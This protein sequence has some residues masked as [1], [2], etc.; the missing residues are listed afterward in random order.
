MRCRDLHIGKDAAINRRDYD[1]QRRLTAPDFVQDDR[2]PLVG[3]DDM[4]RARVAAVA[5]RYGGNPNP[6]LKCGRL[7]IDLARRF[8]GGYGIVGGNLPIAAGFGLA[9]D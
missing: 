4:R 7:E 3:L 2:R 5:R 1:T 8:M 6:L 9:A